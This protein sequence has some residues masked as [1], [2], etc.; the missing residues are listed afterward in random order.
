[1]TGGG[2]AMIYRKHFELTRLVAMQGMMTLFIKVTNISS[3]DKERDENRNESCLFFRNFLIHV[4][5][6]DDINSFHDILN[7]ANNML[8]ASRIL[9]EYLRVMNT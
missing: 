9:E 5:T 6:N 4:N 3:V 7:N 8:L 2:E 1:M